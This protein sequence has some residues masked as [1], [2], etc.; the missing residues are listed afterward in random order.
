ME[1]ENLNQPL[2]IVFFWGVSLV[3]VG[4][5]STFGREH[6]HTVDEPYPSPLRNPGMMRF[7]TARNTGK[8]RGEIPTVPF[9]GDTICRGVGF[10][11]MVSFRAKWTSQPDT[12]PGS[13]TT[14]ETMRRKI[15]PPLPKD[16]HPNWV[17]RPFLSWGQGTLGQSSAGVVS[18]ENPM[19]LP[20]SPKREPSRCLRV[21]LRGVRW[22]GHKTET[23]VDTT[24][25]PKQHD[26]APGLIQRKTKRRL[27]QRE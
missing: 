4:L 24:T 3:F 8:R 2:L 20:R 23:A 12:I 9:H 14:T 21:H 17:P 26:Q 11:P 6:P 19:S 25:H 10:I 13:Q 18:S 1:S 22:I 7:S 27:I 5:Q 15:P 16:C